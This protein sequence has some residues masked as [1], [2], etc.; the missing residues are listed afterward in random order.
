MLVQIAEIRKT[1]LGN[2]GVLDFHQESR[3]IL[4]KLPFYFEKDWREAECKWND[5]HGSC[6]Y[7]LFDQLV[8]FI[9]R[10]TKRANLLE[11]Q[12]ISKPS[13]LGKVAQQ[14]K[15][16][17]MKNVK[18][19][20]TKADG[21]VIKCSY[22]T[23]EHDIDTCEEFLALGRDAALKFLKENKLCFG[24]GCTAEH[25]S[26]QCQ[27]RCT[28]S[29]CKRKHLSALHIEATTKE[30]NSS[31][32]EVCSQPE[33]HDGSDN[34]LIVLLW[35]RSKSNMNSEI[36]CYC[37]IDDQSNTCFMSEVLLEQLDVA[38]QETRL[39]L[40]TVYK[41][42]CVINCKRVADL[43]IFSFDRQSC[44]SLPPIFTRE[45]IPASRSQIPKQHVA[46][47]WDH[48][49]DVANQ[50]PPYQPAIKVSLLIGNNV[51]CVTRP[52]EVV[53]GN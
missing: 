43:E 6:S 5:K 2:L 4:A 31:C 49:K 7:P 11:L 33:Q 21:Q 20:S 30:T 14:E 25:M 29:K 35:V 40:S 18:V 17:E 39:T 52:R 41:R 15:K 46:R 10:R 51:P 28:C 32:T 22:C 23:K 47:Q 19:L 38:G 16:S 44:I 42:K 24:C 13:A 36:L 50:L 3:K 48:L 9:K 26:H 12:T 53:A 34:S 45:I 1:F 8:E 27:S 37:I